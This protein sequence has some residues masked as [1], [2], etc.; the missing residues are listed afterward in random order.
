MPDSFTEMRRRN[1]VRVLELVR[2]NGE[3]SRADLARMADLSKAT[4][5]SITAELIECELLRETG[6]ITTDKG[7]RPVGLVFN[8]TGKL[9][10]GISIDDQ[11]NVSIDITDMDGKL[12]DAV[13]YQESVLDAAQMRAQIT[14]TF[15]A[16]KL[17][18]SRLCAVG[19]AVPGPLDSGVEYVRLAEDIGNMLGRSVSLE[20]LV[21]MAAVAEAHAGKL[22]AD[23][24][25]LFVRTSHRLR[26]TLLNGSSLVYRHNQY[27]G[28]PGHV[29]VPWITDECG[30]GKVGCAN[31]HIGS[32]LL[33][34]RAAKLGL[35]LES[36]SELV[37]LGAAGKSEA[38]SVLND[39]GKATG[40]AI[41]G[42][43]NVLAPVTVIVSGRLNA[44]GEAFFGPLVETCREYATD[45]NFNASTVLPSTLGADSAAIGAALFA[46]S[47]NED[48]IT[49]CQLV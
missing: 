22:P 10:L 47:K 12:I 44:A 46:L 4:V 31:T 11:S 8:P 23:R 25:V 17:D 14:Q 42:L 33:L 48:L 34:K 7:R 32:Q 18:L 9:A 19:L 39:A 15:D 30:C 20:T 16:A 28:E 21:D 43:I 24:L 35:N 6:S 36:V 3:L 27:G 26:S 38:V 37:E 41:A 49:A 40:Y 45:A 1:A 2:S 29:F 13:T 5:S